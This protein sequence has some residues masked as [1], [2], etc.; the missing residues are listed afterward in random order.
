MLT[1]GIISFFFYG[2]AVFHCIYVSLLYPFICKWTFQLFL[3]L[4]CCN[5]A[6]NIGVHELF[7]IIVSSKC[8]PRSRIAGSYGNSVFSSRMSFYIAFHSGCTSSYFHQQCRRIPFPPHPLQHLLSVDFVMM[9]ILTTVR[10][11]P[12]CSFDLPVS[13]Y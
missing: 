7:W 3:C 4:A 12:H 9:A 1:N 11:V 2:W 10:V 8:M 13:D 6:M 5:V